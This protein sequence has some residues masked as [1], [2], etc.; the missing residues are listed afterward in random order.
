MK[1]KF[2]L[3]V[4]T[5]LGHGVGAG[6]GF[7][8]PSGEVQCGTRRLRSH[9]AHT[10]HNTIPAVN[11]MRIEI[12]TT[13]EVRRRTLYMRNVRASLFFEFIG[14]QIKPPPPPPPVG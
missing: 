8:C 3:G 6:S 5:R 1:R 10:G 11:A 14:N 12:K 13:E 2:G 7:G 9:R 4:M